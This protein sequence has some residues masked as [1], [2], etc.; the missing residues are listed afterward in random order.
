MPNAPGSSEPN[1]CAVRRCGMKP[2]IVWFR[3][4]LRLS[5][6]PALA[7][8][9]QSGQPLV[10]LYVLDD[11]TPGDWK[12]GGAARW[13]LH[14]SLAALGK[15]LKGKLVLRRGDAAR[16]VTM[17]AQET[18]ADTVTWNRCY[19]PFAVER[20]RA[21]KAALG[22]TGIA[23]HSFNGALLHEPWEITTGAGKPYRVF[24]PFWN[25]MRHRDVPP[26]LRT[27]TGLRHHKTDGDDLADWNL[28]PSKPDWAT[29]F[30]WTP[31]ENRRR[32]RCM[33]SWTGSRVTRR[34]GTCPIATALRAC[35]PTCTLAKS[36]R[37]KPGMRCAPAT[38]VKAAR[39]S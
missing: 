8:A 13:W 25:A 16:V 22:E 1:P 38:T 30:D 28:L 11:E 34:R 20:D 23:V 9:V 10:C 32:T 12:M 35:R 5:D 37:A 27:P 21:L 31:G 36:R 7:F 3:Q 29:G 4:D 14:H 17:L 39:L 19:E 15:S 24:T 6:N 26:P 33:I 2:V 18:G